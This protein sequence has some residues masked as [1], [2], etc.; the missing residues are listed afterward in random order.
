LTH[1]HASQARKML[2]YLALRLDDAMMA[3]GLFDQ[4][5]NDGTQN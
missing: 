4:G 2:D 1:E 3:A 5:A